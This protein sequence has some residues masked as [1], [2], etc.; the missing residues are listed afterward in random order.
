MTKQELIDFIKENIELSSDYL[1]DSCSN[2]QTVGLKFIGEDECFAEI[3][4]F[5][6]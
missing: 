1:G 2:N 5:I 4:I 3:T 6:D